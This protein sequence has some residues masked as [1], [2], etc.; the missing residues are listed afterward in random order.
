MKFCINTMKKS[1][2]KIDFE[3]FTPQKSLN[4]AVFAKYLPRAEKIL[5]Q[6]GLKNISGRIGLS[7]VDDDTIRKINK[8]YRKKDVPTDVVSLS[9][10]E[11]AC[12]KAVS[13]PVD[14]LIGEIFISVDT[15][16]KQ[17]G[18]YGWSFKEELIFL[19]VHGLLHVFG[20]DHLNDRDKKVMFA[21]QDKILK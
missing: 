19:F 12:N 9:Y 17:A 18:E 14:D 1:Q 5:Q 4:K 8:N 10:T 16:K 20:F 2:I 13:F 15:A 21:M 7:L 6:E 11:N 3:N